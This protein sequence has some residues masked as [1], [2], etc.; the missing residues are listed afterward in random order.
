MVR[1]APINIPRHEYNHHDLSAGKTVAPDQSPTVVDTWLEME[2]LI[3]TGK[4]KS[5]GVSN[6]SIKILSQLLD[7][8]RTK[9]VPAVNQVE[10]HPCLP[11]TN[12][13]EFCESKGILMTAYSPLG[14][15][16]I[17]SRPECFLILWW[18]RASSC[19]FD[20]SRTQDAAPSRGRSCRLYCSE[21][22]RDGCSGVTGVGRPA[23][24]RCYTK[25]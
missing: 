16:C 1:Y 3:E 7:D 22:R 20:A 12:L 6:F 18:F 24:N 23:Q 11:Q 19:S 15:S 14:E 2:K 4:V 25:V 13:K 8:P 9:V 5:I 21:T 17:S 10:M